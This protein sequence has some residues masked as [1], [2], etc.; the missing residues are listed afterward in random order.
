MNRPD[1]LLFDL[2]GT[3]IDSRADLARSIN[4]MLADLGRPNLPEETIASFVG[5]GVK[6][7]TYRSLTAT[8]PQKSPPDAALHRRGLELMGAH[9]ATQML[10]STHLFPR[11]PETLDLLKGRAKGVVTSKEVHFTK[12]ILEHFGIA[13]HFQCIVGGDTLPQHKPDP[14]PVLEALRQ[15]GRSPQGV[16]M[17]GDSENDIYAGRAAGTLT[18]GASYGFRDR[19]QMQAVGPDFLIDSFA[20]LIEH[21][22]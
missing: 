5:D 8:H 20:Q 19:E 1:C 14:A 11:V 22:G 18:C 10:V 7:L 2:D 21:F 3:L 9:Y 15:L 17:I 4:L 12:Q 6:V 16:V 13:G